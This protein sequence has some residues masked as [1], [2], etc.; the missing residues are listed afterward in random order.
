MFRLFK[1]KDEYTN[2]KVKK[3]KKGGKV[4]FLVSI[5]VP[6]LGFNILTKDKNDK[7]QPIYTP[8]TGIETTVDKIPTTEVTTYEYTTIYQQNQEN[9]NN[10]DILS[11]I[12][13]SLNNTSKLLFDDY[14]SKVDVDYKY[15]DLFGIDEALAKLAEE[16]L[17]A[18]KTH[19]HQI[20]LTEEGLFDANII[21]EAV[22]NNNIEYKNDPNLSSYKKAVLN[23]PTESEIRIVCAAL[24]DSLN[25]KIKNYP[26]I[27]IEELR[28]VVG[29]LKIFSS[30]STSNAYVNHDDCLVISPNMIKLVTTMTGDKNSQTNIIKHESN[31]LAQKGCCDRLLESNDEKKIVGIT[32]EWET[33]KVNPLAWKWFYEGS[34]EKEMMKESNCEAITYAALV[35]YLDSLTMATILDKDIPIDYTERLCFQKDINKIFEQFNCVTQEE[36]EEIIKMMYSIDIIQY[37]KDDFYKAYEQVYGEEKNDT[38]IVKIQRELKVPICTT[39]TKVF[40][41]NLSEYLVS[42]QLS[43]Q[44]VFYLIRVFEGDLNSHLDCANDTKLLNNTK[45]MESY[46][47]IQNEFFYQMSETNSI[48]KETLVE[49]FNNYT[50]E[51]STDVLKKLDADKKE[52]IINRYQAVKH[53]ATSSI[54][55]IKETKTEQITKQK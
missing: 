42:N 6:V 41:S 2:A 50:V 31:H 48:N 8:E 45:F 11:K 21:M 38:T 36:K 4:K 7:P 43:L 14:L 10:N 18:V 17:E 30:P 34:A 37:S 55:N 24:A 32:R 46:T 26:E 29:N 54:A 39:L 44:D 52:F 51:G 20:E 22:K 5:L 40:Y 47:S 35:S 12:N 16:N 1:K 3:E 33:L 13:V 49:Y 28:C 23:N 15:D 27:D 19:T 53:R 25:I 9:E